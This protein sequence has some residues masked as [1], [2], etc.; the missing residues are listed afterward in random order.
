LLP[1]KSLE[2]TADAV[3]ASPPRAFNSLSS[4]CKL[5]HNGGGGGG[6]AKGQGTVPVTPRDL[7]SLH[8]YPRVLLPRLITFALPSRPLH[9]YFRSLYLPT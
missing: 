7:A 9:V 1:N 4:C 3:V 6:H 8:R 2:L 5:S